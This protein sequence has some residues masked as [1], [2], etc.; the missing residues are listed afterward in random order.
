MG[1]QTNFLITY[2]FQPSDSISSVAGMFGTDNS[3]IT[4]LNGENI[5][6]FSTVLVPVSRIPQLQQPTA[7]PAASSCERKG[8][9]KG[10]VVG[11]GVLGAL[12]FVSIASIAW[13]WWVL[14]RRGKKRGEEEEKAITTKKMVEKQRFG[15]VSATDFMAD[16]SDCLDKYKLY[17]VEELR[18]ATSDFDSKCLIQGSVYKGFMRGDAFAIKK[19]KWNAYEE[20]KILQKVYAFDPFI[21]AFLIFSVHFMSL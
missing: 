13:L 11:L 6:S 5:R 19:M 9:A 18:E 8:V 14:L 1:N 15:S 16:V 20:L 17:G 4:A 3:S 2:V 21:F 10:A 12:L 7:S